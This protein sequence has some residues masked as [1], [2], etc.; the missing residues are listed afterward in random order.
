MCKL[1]QR[2]WFDIGFS[3]NGEKIVAVVRTDGYIYGSSD[4]G[5]T[6]N[7]FVNSGLSAM[8]SMKYRN[9]SMN[10]YCILHLYECIFNY[11]YIKIYC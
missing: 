4:Y 2:D 11:I 8:L 1:G 5:V 7:A 6:W 10:Q 3:D 9:Y